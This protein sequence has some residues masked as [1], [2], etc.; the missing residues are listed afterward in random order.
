[1]NRKKVQ[2]WAYEVGFDLCGVTDGASLTS[3]RQMLF[4]RQQSGMQT[5]IEEEDIEKRISPS[6][7]L[8]EFHSIITLGLS[9]HFESENSSSSVFRLS[10]SSMGLDYHL[11]MHGLLKKLADRLSDSTGEIF[12][13]S[14]D[15]YPLVERE[16]ACDSGIGFYGK[17]CSII[18]PVFGSFIFLGEIITTMSFEKTDRMNSLCGTCD[19]CIRACPAGALSE[20]GLNAKKCLSYITQKKGILTPEEGKLIGNRLYGCDTCQDVC[21]W[22]R[23]AKISRGD[24]FGLSDFQGYDIRSLFSMSNREFQ[25]KYSH[26]AASWRGKNV[27]KRNAVYNI[28]NRRAEEYYDLVELAKKDSSEGVQ[29]AACEGVLQ[30]KI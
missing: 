10:R 26:I 15:T 6:H 9:Y 16:L 18:H 4:Q 19:R 24:V 5:D 21:P 22:N 11:V 2:E 23:K 8:S 27:L 20:F 7:L 13:I 29:K 30:K 28:L 14:V 3:L 12:R 25:E 17:N 1:M